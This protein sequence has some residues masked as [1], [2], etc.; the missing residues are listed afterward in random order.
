MSYGGS[1]RTIYIIR[2]GEKPTDPNPGSATATIGIDAYGNP[3]GSSLTPFG[4]QRAGALTTLFAPYDTQARAWVTTPGQ[5]Y[6]PSYSGDPPSGQI[7]VH[8]TN[9]TIY[10]ISQFLSMTIDNTTYA[11]GDETTMG[12][13]LAAQP[14]PMVTLVCWEHS[15]IPTIA[16]AIVGPSGQSQIPQTWPDDRYD[17]VWAFTRAVPGDP[18]TFTQYPE[19]LLY[20]DS[21]TTI[22]V[23]S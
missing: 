4:W 8:R 11:E 1:T 10:A 9:E 15:A 12:T 16:N 19:M 3:S 23:G 22:P 20:G 18:Y 21:L 2:H 5:M 13:N 6:S 7:S 17:V 14:P